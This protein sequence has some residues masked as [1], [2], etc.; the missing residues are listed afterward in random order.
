MVGRF[1]GTQGPPRLLKG[2][3]GQELI[4]IILAVGILGMIAAAIF[5]FLGDEI[6]AFAYR[7]IG[8]LF[9]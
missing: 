3:R 9:H 4:H 8:N 5:Y 7:T 6:T 2:H 1:W